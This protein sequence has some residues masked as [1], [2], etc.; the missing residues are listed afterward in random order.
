MELFERIRY[1]SRIKKISLAKIAA[2]IGESPQNFNQWFKPKS[3]RRLWEH[4][5]KILELF[6]DVRREWLYFGQEPAFTDGK[7]AEDLPTKEEVQALKEEIERLK[8]ELLEAN[9]QYRQ[10]SARLLIDGVGD[11]NAA[12]GIGK[13]AG[14]QG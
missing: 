14:G 6:P 3:Q 8:T 4:L 11:K 2:H 13:A 9:R 1:L 7:Q 12:T 10:L 5:P